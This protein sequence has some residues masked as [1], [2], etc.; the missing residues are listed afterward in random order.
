MQR[1]IERVLERG[2]ETESHREKR[3]T[4]RHRDRKEWDSQREREWERQGKERMR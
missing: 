1:E 2:R 4:D 3:E